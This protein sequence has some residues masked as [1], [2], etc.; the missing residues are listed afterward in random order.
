MS[1]GNFSL[2]RNDTS[3]KQSE[4]GVSHRWRNIDTFPSSRLPGKK[5]FLTRKRLPLL[6][7]QAKNP[8]RHLEKKLMLRLDL[9]KFLFDKRPVFFLGRKNI[10][11]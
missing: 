7:F 11:S 8:S 4:S 9:D 3:E 1:K 10:Q 2:R 6:S 5:I